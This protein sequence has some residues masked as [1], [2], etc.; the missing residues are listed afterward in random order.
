[1]ELKF[2]KIAAKEGQKIIDN[3]LQQTTTQ[4]QVVELKVDIEYRRARQ[5]TLRINIQFNA[6]GTG[7]YLSSC[8][9]MN[10]ITLK[11]P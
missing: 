8:L 3:K 4:T 2:I 11:M 9:P 5:Q 1:M 10:K 7:L 6:L